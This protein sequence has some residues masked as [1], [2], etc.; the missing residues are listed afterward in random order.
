MP[1]FLQKPFAWCSVFH[2]FTL[3]LCL[4][5]QLT[6][7]PEGSIQQDFI[8]QPIPLLSAFQLV[9]TFHLH[10]GR[11]LIYEDL[12]QPFYLLLFGISESSVF[13]FLCF[14]LLFQ[15]GGILFFCLS[16][17]PFVMLYVSV[18]DFWFVVTTRFVQHR[19]LYMYNCLF[20][21]HCIY[22]HS[23]VQVQS[24]PDSLFMNCCYK[25]SLFMLYSYFVTA[26][27]STLLLKVSTCF[28]L[29]VIVKCLIPYCE[30]ELQFPVSVCLVVC[31]SVLYIFVFLFE[32]EELFSAFLEMR[33][34]CKKL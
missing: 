18:L 4:S 15:L 7:S 16:V 19:K 8:F 9:S 2:L 24:F 10:L 12:L 26:I 22:F 11:L 17:F 28:N 23:H 31:Y 33:V 25:F 32:V 14:C 20:S 3:S 5:L 29:Y 1:T 13:L 21:S 30:Q 34:L 6:L 27:A